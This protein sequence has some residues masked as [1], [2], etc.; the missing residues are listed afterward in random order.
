MINQFCSNATAPQPLDVQWFSVLKMYKC[1][2]VIV[3]VRIVV[4]I[5]VCMSMGMH[6]CIECVIMKISC[7]YPL[8]DIYLSVWLSFWSSVCLSG[9]LSVFLVVC[10]SVCLSLLSKITKDDWPLPPIFLP[11]SLLGAW[12]VSNKEWCSFNIML[13]YQRNS[14]LQWLLRN[15][16]M[17]FDTT[18]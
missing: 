4:I 1:A 7:K 11:L 18:E 5:Y 8:S 15:E 2:C 3:H 6:I 13:L 10:L 16:I 12:W 14:T 9:R 17:S